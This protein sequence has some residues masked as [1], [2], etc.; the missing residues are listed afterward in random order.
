MNQHWICFGC[1]RLKK[2]VIM[3]RNP[4]QGR[5]TNK[6]YLQLRLDVQ[7]AGSTSSFS[8]LNYVNNVLN[9]TFLESITFLIVVQRP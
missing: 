6:N 7:K 4:E 1:K 5:I 8:V 9:L 2:H 3:K